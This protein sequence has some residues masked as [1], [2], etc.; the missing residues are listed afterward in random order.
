MDPGDKSSVHC[1]QTLLS[2]LSK[3]IEKNK[4]QLFSGAA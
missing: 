3:K 1:A 2:I 4:T